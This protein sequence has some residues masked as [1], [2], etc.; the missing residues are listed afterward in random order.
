MEVLRVLLAMCQYGAYWWL[1]GYLTGDTRV[2]RM[3]FIE[4]GGH[5]VF[6]MGS[7]EAYYVED[8][9]GQWTFMRQGVSPDWEEDRREHMREVCH[10]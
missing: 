2:Q 7:D 1:D 9:R 10:G 8:F 5:L 3:V 6:L 4:R